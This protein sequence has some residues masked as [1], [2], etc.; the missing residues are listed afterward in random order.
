MDRA[1][2]AGA[3]M[4]QAAAGREIQ[5]DVQAAQRGVEADVSDGPG[6][7]LQAEG[8][9]EDLFFV[10]APECARSRPGWKPRE[11]TSAKGVGPGTGAPPRLF[12]HTL[13]SGA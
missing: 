2:L 11:E 13:S 4:G 7:A 3:G 5:I 12:T 9:S 8:Q 10:H 6:G 1:G